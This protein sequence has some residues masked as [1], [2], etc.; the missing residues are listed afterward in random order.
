MQPEELPLLFRVNQY[1]FSFQIVDDYYGIDYD[2]PHPSEEYDGPSNET[3]SVEVPV[4]EM[5][6]SQKDYQR[7]A[8]SINPLRESEFYGVDIYADVLQIVG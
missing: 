6:V 4:T 2:G 1:T 7:V 8:T 3:S 5:S